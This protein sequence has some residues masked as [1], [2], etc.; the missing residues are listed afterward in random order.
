MRY[1]G[2]FWKNEMEYTEKFDDYRELQPKERE[3]E[4]NV[5]KN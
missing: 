2:D 4:K 5:I 3:R 1:L